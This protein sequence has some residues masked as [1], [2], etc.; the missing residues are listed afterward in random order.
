MWMTWSCESTASAPSHSMWLLYHASRTEVTRVSTEG[1]DFDT[2]LA[3]Y[4]WDGNSSHALNEIACDNN[5]GFDGS[6]S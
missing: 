6:D 2:V 3:V 1:S 4:T 5:S